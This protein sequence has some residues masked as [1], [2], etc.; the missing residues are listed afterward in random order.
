[1]KLANYK[2]N[3]EISIRT[4]NDLIRWQCFQRLCSDRA[5]HVEFGNK[6]LPMRLFPLLRGRAKSEVVLEIFGWRGHCSVSLTRRVSSK[7]F[8]NPIQT[9]VH[10]P[11]ISNGDTFINDRE[12]E[13]VVGPDE[14]RDVRLQL[15]ID[16]RLTWCTFVVRGRD[17]HTCSRRS[18]GGYER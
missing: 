2:C 8:H 16:A 4:R 6:T 7:G 3:E 17:K 5:L 11:Q 14:D 15:S 18:L 1:M 13:G 12:F 9:D 10:R